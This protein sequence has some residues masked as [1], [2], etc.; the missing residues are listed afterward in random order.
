MFEE[1][2]TKGVIGLVTY[3]LIWLAM[4]GVLLVSF[5]RRRGFYQV[6]IAIMGLLRRV[7]RPEPVPVRHD[8][9]DDAVRTSGRVS[10]LRGAPAWRVRR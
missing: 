7:L 2:T 5:R 4:A 10:D 9:H 6:F 1:L 3:L 8:N